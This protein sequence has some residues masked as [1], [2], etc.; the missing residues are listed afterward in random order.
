MRVGDIPSSLWAAGV[1]LCLSF[2]PKLSEVVRWR[3]SVGI[4][5][6]R[7]GVDAL[8]PP[9]PISKTSLSGLASTASHSDRI[10]SG[11]PAASKV[12]IS[13]AFDW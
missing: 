5:F 13:V 12:I 3:P 1:V 7:G 11:F 2:I 6:K 4:G 10:L 9:P 8:P